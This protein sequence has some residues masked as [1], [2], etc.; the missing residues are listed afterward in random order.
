MCMHDVCVRESI[1]VYV[2][3]DICVELMHCEGQTTMLGVSPC[4]PPWA[5]VSIMTNLA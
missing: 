3:A 1:H 5:T 2:S 4:L